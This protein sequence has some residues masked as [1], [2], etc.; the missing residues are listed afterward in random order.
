M[1]DKE[2]K[3]LNHAFGYSKFAKHTVSLLTKESGRLEHS[4]LPNYTI[5]FRFCLLPSAASCPTTNSPSSA[6]SPSLVSD[7]T[8]SY[9]GDGTEVY[10]HNYTGKC[11][12]SSGQE[13]A[14]APAPEMPQPTTLGTHLSQVNRENSAGLIWSTAHNIRCA[15]AAIKT[16]WSC[17]GISVFSCWRVQRNFLVMWCWR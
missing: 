5:F 13:T 15:R 3:V 10:L 16:R 12:V 1:I 7:T 17:S 8:Q 2:Y 6:A 9:W 11:I 4:V 14:P